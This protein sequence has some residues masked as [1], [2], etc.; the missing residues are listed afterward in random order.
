MIP[1]TGSLS[2]V[3]GRKNLLLA[4]GGVFILGSLLCG[5]AQDMIS[6]VTFRAIQG[7]GAG[8]IYSVCSV[9]LIGKR[10]GGDGVDTL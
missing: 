6:L 7:L 4:S 1:I 2:E 10:R 5:V 3:V 8:P 9:S